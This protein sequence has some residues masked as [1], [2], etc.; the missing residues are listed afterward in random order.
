VEKI[1]R[2]S[3]KSQADNVTWLYSVLSLSPRS[4]HDEASLPCVMLPPAR[5]SKFF[6]REDIIVKVE[7]HFKG[8]GPGSF[9]SVALYGLGGVGKTHVAMKY[10]EKQH[11]KRE[12]N[13]VLWIEAESDMELKQS[14]TK[15]AKALKLPGTVPHSHDDNRLLVMNWLHNTS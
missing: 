7:D 13:A 11:V 15:I 12:V 5:S 10:A 3:T 4:W 9:R 2:F 6:D 8:P 14:F 1:T